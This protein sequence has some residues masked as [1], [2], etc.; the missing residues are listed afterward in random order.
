MVGSNSLILFEIYK[1][2]HDYLIVL[3]LNYYRIIRRKIPL[4]YGLFLMVGYIAKTYRCND[5]DM[6]Q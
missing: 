1:K 3:Y 5:N 6:P 4:G 2:K